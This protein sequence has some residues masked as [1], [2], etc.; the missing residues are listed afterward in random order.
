[1]T[2][3]RDAHTDN[4]VIG[5]GEV[6]IDVH[7]SAGKKTGERYLGDT[8]E[9]TLSIET[10]S[11]DVISSDGPVAK[12][13]TKHNSQLTRTLSC[14]IRDMS[15]DNLALFAAGDVVAVAADVTAVVDEEI[16]VKRGLWFSLGAS[17]ANPAGHPK[18][19]AAGIT[20]KK[21]NAAVAKADNYEVDADHGRIHILPAAA[22][23]ADG[24]TLK[25]SYTPARPA[26]KRI[27][28]RSQPIYAAL[29]YLEDAA[30]G[31]GR[32]IYIPR[33]SIAPSGELALK[34]RDSE[35]QVKIVATAMHPGGDQEELYI[36]EAV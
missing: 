18:V 23:I 33:A 19:N 10:Q 13:L 17:A 21:G 12:M 4:I 29:R 2:A 20:V 27:T 31:S 34:S 25:I 35:Q 3:A 8:P 36:E 26:G 9:A 7:D 30:T 1:M 24:D 16:K 28:P 15:L 5:A 14:T 22:G 6:Y 11:V 32:N